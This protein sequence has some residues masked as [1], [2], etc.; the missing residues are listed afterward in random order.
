MEPDVKTRPIL[1]HV[2]IV[3]GGGRGLGRAMALGL[4]HA[5]IRSEEHT[6]EL[7]SHS[8]LV[9]R[10]LLEKKKKKKQRTDN[11]VKHRQSF[12]RY[13]QRKLCNL[14]LTARKTEHSCI[15]RERG[16]SA[17][18]TTDLNITE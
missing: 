7:Q 1:S 12:K 15:E 17:V 9:C 13:M 5:G 18:N 8:D 6:S 14:K 16:N 2:A 10:L 11:S 4:A 3:T